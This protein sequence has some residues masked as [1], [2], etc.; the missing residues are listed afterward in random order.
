[1]FSSTVPHNGVEDLRKRKTER[2]ERKELEK[3]EFLAAADARKATL[4][5]N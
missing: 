5:N 1:M 4:L 3:A 2:T